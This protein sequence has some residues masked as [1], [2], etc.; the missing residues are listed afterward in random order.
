MQTANFG[1]VNQSLK[2]FGNAITG[3][4]VTGL[5][6]LFI[7]FFIV[8]INVAGYEPNVGWVAFGA[9][10]LYA[11]S[12][13]VGLGIFGAF[14]KITAKAIVEGLGGSIY[15]Y[16]DED[17]ASPNFEPQ[18]SGEQILPSDVEL[19]DES[20]GEQLTPSQ[21]E[22]WIAAGK[23]DLRTWFDSPSSNFRRWLNDNS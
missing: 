12:G 1:R 18:V 11:G 21:K 19:P 10:M 23:P 3:L 2:S 13:L 15:E 16:A 4:V 7:G 17:I 14:L 22:Q 5:S 6:L 9:I 8:L 20:L